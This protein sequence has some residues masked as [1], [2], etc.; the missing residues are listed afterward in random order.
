MDL[1]QFREEMVK[2]CE[3]ILS[4]WE[5]NALD[6]VNGGF[7]GAID[8]DMTKHPEA[9]KGAVLNAR[10]LWTFSSA[11]RIL[12]HEKYLKLANRAYDY[13]TKN[14]ID[15]KN[16]G[17]YWMLD[18]KGKPVNTRNQI[19]AIAFV[20]YGLV[21][22]Y[23]I[24][25]KQE[26]LDFANKLYNSIQNHSFDPK[27]NGY[28]EAYSQDWKLLEDLRLSDKDK[29]EPKTMNTHLHILE[30]FAALYNVTKNEKL[31]KELKNL[32]VEVFLKK[33]LDEKKGSFGLFY[34]VDWTHKST[35]NSYGHDI[36]GSWLLWEAG[37]F[38]NDEEVTKL[39]K[40]DCLK[41]AEQCLRDGV[42]KED[43]S[44][45]N[46]GVD[47]KIEDS[48]KHWWVQAESVVGFFNA[49]QITKDEKFLKA[50]VNTWE[51]IKKYI[52][53]HKNGEW[54]WRVN[55]KHE[56]Y[57]EEQKAGPWK[58]PYHNSRM[59]MQIIERIDSMLK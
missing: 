49:Y 48:D 15:Q 55:K 32:I 33:I 29:N 41:L 51:F 52:I 19:Y 16:N 1:K 37:E 23:K 59:C 57:K 25:K 24:T 40:V 31:G 35:Q 2:E 26:A 34:D 44:M 11:Y 4:F 46:E 36:E 30:A 53:D 58:C 42:D 5:T 12:K 50:S 43:G 18:C 8:L 13:V 9:D 27:L 3:N 47:G 45:M 38:L 14:F 56:V 54:F 21:E 7:I 6:E 10:I 20:I 28:F 17:V 22:Y 39:L